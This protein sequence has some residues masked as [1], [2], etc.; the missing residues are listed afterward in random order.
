MLFCQFE[1]IENPLNND[2]QCVVSLATIAYIGLMAIDSG[3]NITSS[4][5]SKREVRMFF[6]IDGISC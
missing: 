5:F 4:L 2:A 6:Q 3:S 1:R